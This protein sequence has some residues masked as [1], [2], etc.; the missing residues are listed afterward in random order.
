MLKV[1]RKWSKPFL[2]KQQ[3]RHAWFYPKPGVVLVKNTHGLEQKQAWFYP[4][5]RVGIEKIKNKLEFG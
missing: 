1:L 5:A 4:K 3:T 2:T